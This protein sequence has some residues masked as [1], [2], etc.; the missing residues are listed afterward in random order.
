[1]E[2]VAHVQKLGH[3]S[4][5][6]S[7]GEVAEGRTRN[8]DFNALCDQF[9]AVSKDHFMQRGFHGHCKMMIGRESR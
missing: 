4:K 7:S 8:T 5:I 2:R 3:F 6:G 1:M 9:A